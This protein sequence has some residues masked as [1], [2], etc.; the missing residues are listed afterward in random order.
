MSISRYK[1]YLSQSLLLF[2]LQSLVFNQKLQDK[3]TREK[4]KSTHCQEIKEST[5]PDEEMAPT[6][7]NWKT[8]AFNSI[9]GKI[10]KLG[11]WET[12]Q[13]KITQNEAQKTRR[14]SIQKRGFKRDRGKSK[15]T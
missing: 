7:A 13:M 4:K 10:E 1:H 9:L 3:N 12:G 2:Y 11:N 8:N 6:S 5:E 14:W 15:K